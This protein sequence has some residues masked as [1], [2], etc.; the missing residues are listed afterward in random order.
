MKSPRKAYWHASL[1]RPSGV[2]RVERAC[3]RASKPAPFLLFAYIHT[4]LLLTTYL[5]HVLPMHHLSSSESRDG[6]VHSSLLERAMEQAK[7][8]VPSILRDV[9]GADNTNNTNISH[10]PRRSRRW[11]R[12]LCFIHV[13]ERDT[14][15]NAIMTRVRME[16]VVIII[17]WVIQ[18][19][20]WLVGV[21]G[22]YL[23]I[24]ED[25]YSYQR[26]HLLSLALVSPP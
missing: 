10:I 20:W 15:A 26:I 19:H 25:I 21:G 13:D 12:A 22:M 7:G 16:V 11:G 2:D 5:T 24:W 6:D 3:R 1:K 23:G 17:R 4:N 18:W 8:D 9:E 14:A